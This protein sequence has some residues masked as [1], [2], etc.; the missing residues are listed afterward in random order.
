[1]VHIEP[2]ADDFPRL[3]FLTG[4]FPRPNPCAIAMSLTPKLDRDFDHLRNYF[5]ASPEHY[6]S[7]SDGPNVSPAQLH[8]PTQFFDAR[9]YE[10]LFLHRG[11][12]PLQQEPAFDLEE[13]ED[14]VIEERTQPNTMS[15]STAAPKRSTTEQIPNLGLET[16]VPDD[17]KDDDGGMK[18]DES[19]VGVQPGSPAKK[20]PRI[21]CSRCFA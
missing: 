13:I 16:A 3:I 1:M 4:D 6:D 10:Q 12:P 14:T 9:G 17:E 19:H 21:F 18:V 5:N 8:S 20:N 15:S 11:A 2:V 7:G